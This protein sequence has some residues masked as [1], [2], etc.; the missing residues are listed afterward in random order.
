MEICQRK[1]K[2]ED[3]LGQD[4]K[5]RG[6]DKR[7]EDIRTQEGGGRGGESHEECRGEI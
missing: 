6:E 1:E 7:E 5:W 4:K 3:D 2:Q